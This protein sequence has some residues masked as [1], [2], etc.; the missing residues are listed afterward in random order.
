MPVLRPPDLLAPATRAGGEA[1]PAPAQRS[2]LGRVRG[3]PHSRRPLGG[4]P[5]EGAV[6]DGGAVPAGA[7]QVAGVD[8][9]PVP[10][11]D[12]HLHAGKAIARLGN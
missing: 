12:A 9:G 2:P 11:R 4:V 7:R 6:P 1:A 10:H 3:R 8:G 5:G